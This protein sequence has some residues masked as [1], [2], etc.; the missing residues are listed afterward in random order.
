MAVNSRE[1]LIEYCLRKLGSPVIEINVDPDQVEDRVDEA[2]Q[3]YQEYHSDATLKTYFKYKVTEED[4]EN[5]Y[6]PLPPDI[7]FLSRLFPV[8]SSFNNSMNFFDVKY[9]MMLNDIADL[10]NF[11]GDLAYYDQMQQYL[12]MIDMKLSGHPQVSFSR[13]QGRLYIFGDF[14][15]KDIQPDDF[16]IAEVYS[17]IDPEQH[18]LIYDD[19]FIKKYTTALIKRQWGTNLM[20]FEGMQLPGGVTLNGRM[21]YEDAIQEIEKL[22]EEIRLSAELPP[23]FFTG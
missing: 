6:I 22:E 15:D 10:Q 9:Q 23:D 19:K 17:I 20:K 14:E 4:V 18:G 12:S 13:R 8:S 3:Y 7:I 1:E 16:L 21:I 2:L 11:A 5:G